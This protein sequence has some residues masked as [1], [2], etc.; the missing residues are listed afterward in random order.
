MPLSAFSRVLVVH[1]ELGAVAVAEIELR[2]IAVQMLFAAMLIDA[3]HAALEDREE[4][5]DRV[6]MRSRRERIRLALWLT[7]CDVELAA[8]LS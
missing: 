2:Q 3:L 7:V 8:D 5:F 1:A 6:R 4:A